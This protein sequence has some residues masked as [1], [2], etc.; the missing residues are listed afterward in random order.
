[1]AVSNA[2]AVYLVLRNWWSGLTTQTTCNDKKE[3]EL[4]AT[5]SVQGETALSNA[6]GVAGQKGCP[7]QGRGGLWVL[8]RL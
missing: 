5:S 3:D 8:H 7:R 4:R 1:M 6:E 2:G